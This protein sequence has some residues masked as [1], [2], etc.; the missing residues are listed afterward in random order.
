MSRH[1]LIPTDF[2][3]SQ[4]CLTSSLL[5]ASR[6]SL[7]GKVAVVTGAAKGIGKA[8]AEIFLQNGAKVILLD[9]DELA[10]KSLKND[11]DQQ[12]G[13]DRS[14]FMKCSVE[15]NEDIKAALQS[16]ID[17]FGSINILCNNAG[18]LKEDDW[19]KTVSIN[20]G[21]VIRMTYAALEHM[22]KLSGGQGGVVVNTSSL[23]GIEPLS[24][25]PAYSAYQA[26][27]GRLYTSNGSKHART[28]LY[29]IL[30][31]F[32]FLNVVFVVQAASSSSEYGIRFNVI[33][34]VRV[35]T[36]F[37]SSVSQNFGRFSHLL[38][39][40]QKS[41]ERALDPSEVAECILDLVT[42][43]M[44]NGETVLLGQSGRKCVTFPQNL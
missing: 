3:H 27:S 7:S 13:E 6:M 28:L 39:G 16:T 42:D 14:L 35:Q 41:A 11:L 38:G 5:E 26:W 43:E 40:L 2:T 44:K 9:V 36:D 32:A 21:G 10:G 24:S 22:N 30:C 33:C 18:I 12:F 23:A 19:E 8:T 25:C 37:F 17:T 20:L 15:S 4:P 34:P 31:H 29:K 1:Q